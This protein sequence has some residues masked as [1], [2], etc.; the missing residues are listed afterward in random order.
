MGGRYVGPRR[1]AK[2]AGAEA[3]AMWAGRKDQDRSH[4]FQPCAF[5]YR[6]FSCCRWHC[7]LVVPLLLLP[8]RCSCCLCL[9]VR[10][11]LTPEIRFLQDDT[12][13]RTERIY[14]L[15]DQVGPGWL[16]GPVWRCPCL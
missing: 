10:L 8:L 13:E 4:A 1:A 11:R 14:R 16:V 9:Q 3:E 7:L 15:L 5:A 2:R 6:L 12:I